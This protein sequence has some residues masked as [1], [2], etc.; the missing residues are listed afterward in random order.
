MKKFADNPNMFR[1]NH[2]PSPVHLSCCIGESE[3]LQKNHAALTKP[4]YL[5]KPYNFKTLT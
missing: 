4:V 3:M 5:A 2:P 1:K